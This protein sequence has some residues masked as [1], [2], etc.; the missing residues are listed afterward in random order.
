MFGVRHPK[1]PEGSRFMANVQKRQLTEGERLQRDIATAEGRKPVDTQPPPC[2]CAGWC[3]AQD[4]P[5]CLMRRL[6]GQ[7]PKEGLCSSFKT[8]LTQPQINERLS[9]IAL[10]TLGV[11]IGSE[12]DF[13]SQ[14]ET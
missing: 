7:V 9:K 4:A 3:S 8:D 14:T 13:A 1:F 6:G 12:G 11:E 10:G 2:L 5:R